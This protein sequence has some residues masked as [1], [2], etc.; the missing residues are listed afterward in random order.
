MTT[1]TA[2]FT[3]EC[4][5]EAKALLG[6][7]RVIRKRRFN[8]LRGHVL[9]VIQAQHFLGGNEVLWLNAFENNAFN[10]KLHELLTVGFSAL[11][12]RLPVSPPGRTCPETARYRHEAGAEELSLL[13]RPAVHSLH[14]QQG[15]PVV[16]PA[17]NP[18]GLSTDGPSHAVLATKWTILQPSVPQACPLPSG[19]HCFHIMPFIKPGF[20]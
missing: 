13:S 19:G 20:S 3:H 6:L 17:S 18:S 15:W 14:P 2:V 10:R 4:V 5:N 16:P 7:S 9:K 12:A 8:V 11:G 1:E